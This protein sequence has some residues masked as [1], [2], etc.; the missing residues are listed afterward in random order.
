MRAHA[1]ELVKKVSARTRELT[2][3]NEQLKELDQLKS[4]FVSDVSHEL[5]TPVSVLK[6]Y[7]NLLTQGDPQK[8]DDYITTLKNQTSR[9]EQLIED[10]LDL[11]RL[12]SDEENR[13]WAA[14]DLNQIVEQALTPLQSQADTAKL[15]LSFEPDSSLPMVMGN[16]QQLTQVVTNL[17]SNAINYTPSGHV[18]V[19]VDFD[20]E[21]K[22]VR[23]QVQD[24]GMGIEPE[25]Q[26]HLF[27]RFY[28][29]QRVSRSNIRGTGLGLAI[30]KEIVDRHNGTVDVQSEVGVG[31]TFRVYLPVVETV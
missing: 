5:R 8:R 26:P 27:A 21:R 19:R 20:A 3:A 22:Q 31:S 28:R 29:G 24:S 15:E 13:G 16:S 10:I 25:D 9:L 18:A 2:E 11:S 17:V 1:A 23:L 14:L 6:L 4:K 7:L 12:E 30:V